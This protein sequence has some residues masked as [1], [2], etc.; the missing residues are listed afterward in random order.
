[1]TCML[2]IL[3]DVCR[4][5]QRFLVIIRQL[6]WLQEDLQ[7]F[8]SKSENEKNRVF[9]E[10]TGLTV[11]PPALSGMNESDQTFFVD[12]GKGFKCPTH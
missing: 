9:L 5:R 10:N 11:R 6:C 2:E 3:N 8:R 4:F 12:I 7:C 1:M